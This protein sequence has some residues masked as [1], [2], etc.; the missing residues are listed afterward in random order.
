ML[1]ESNAITLIVQIITGASL[2]KTST[3]SDSIDKPHEVHFDAPASTAQVFPLVQNEGIIAL[4]LL[5]ASNLFL[6]LVN[7]QVIARITKY[8]TSLIPTF[9]TIL[10]YKLQNDEIPIYT[11]EAKTNVLTLLKLLVEN[12]SS[13]LQQVLNGMSVCLELLATETFSSNCTLPDEVSHDI[14]KEPLLIRSNSNSFKFKNHISKAELD[15]LF[16]GKASEKVSGVSIQQ[17]L[18]DL[19]SVLN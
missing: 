9:V 19:V 4:A 6:K 18:Y 1:L 13:F 17:A 16:K 5:C 12:D 7:A 8:S 11:V 10:N 15:R 2:M 3:K 14:L